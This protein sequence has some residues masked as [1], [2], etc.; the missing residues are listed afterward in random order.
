MHDLN[1]VRPARARHMASGGTVIP[2]VIF[3]KDGTL[4]P[5]IAARKTERA[6]L[7]VID[8]A[9]DR[10]Y[11]LNWASIATFAVACS[12]VFTDFGQLHKH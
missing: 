7:Q 12:G 4:Q 1:S 6:L 9:E 2:L 5:L 10:L 11:R 8:A 3:Q